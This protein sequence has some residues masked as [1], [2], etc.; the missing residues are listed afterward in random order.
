MPIPVECPS[1]KSTFR[2]KEEFV[3]KLGRCPSCKAQLTV[4]AASPNPLASGDRVSSHAQEGRHATAALKEP[5]AVPRKPVGEEDDDNGGYALA[6]GAANKAKV[7]R[8]RDGGVPGVGASAE[9]VRQ[10]AAPTE[11]TRTS[12]EI[13]TAFRG[14]IA[15]VRPSPMYALWL[16][17]V[18]GFM[19]LLPLI[20]VAIIGLVIFALGYHAVYDVAMLQQAGRG[21]ALK[22]ALMV[23]IV[24]L[25]CGA[26]VVAFLLK[27]LFAKPAKRPKRRAV[28]PKAEPLLYAF[29]DGVCTSVGA[30]RP[31][32]I[33]VDC[34]VNAAAGYA[35]GAFSIFGRKPVLVIGLGLVA[36]LDLKQL[37]GVMAHE[38]GHISQGSGARL[39][40]VISS[41][42][43]WFARVVYER[44]EW[45]ETLRGWSTGD[46][47]AEIVI[48][49]LARLAV[50]LARRV[51]W[52]L[53]HAG[54]LVN[55]VFLR[56]REY[57]ADRYEA[58]MVGA[59]VFVKTLRRIN[60]L[61]LA[62]Q[63]AMSDIQS[64]WQQR[65]LPDNYP[66]LILANVPQIP[67]EALAAYRKA[68]DQVRTGLFDTHPSDRDRIARAKG[69]GQGDGIFH[70]DGPASD[71][72]RDFD[73]LAR[74]VTFDYY[75][76]ILG[77]DI[78]REQLY[79][80]A[81]L[82]E[83][84]A[85]AQEGHVAAERFF[86][87]ALPMSR[88]LALPP[89]YPA[90]PSDPKGAKHAL[91]KARTGQQA[92][93]EEC[94]AANE[95]DSAIHVRL[96]QT[97]AAVI[98]LKSGNTLAADDWGLRA[99]TL[100]AAESA[101]DEA[102]AEL[103]DLAVQFE[104][105]ATAATRRLT[106]AL[107]MLQLDAVAD[108]AAEGRERREEART[109]YPCAA[110]LAANVV[111]PLVRV[112]RA[113]QVLGLL[114]ARCTEGNNATNQ[115]LINAVLRGA[116]DLSERLRELRS[117]LGDAIDYPFEHAREDI[118]LG[119]FALPAILPAETDVVG[120]LETANTAIDRLMGLYRRT[121]GRLTVTAEEVERVLGLGPIAID[122]SE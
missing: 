98:L 70:L 53:L 90:A 57:D 89:N 13:L 17:I 29:I 65:R 84:Q 20:Y 38:L 12:T 32:R 3:G 31:E 45:D 69:E 77:R 10:A 19:V 99:P 111:S 40:D 5:A 80:V 27:P 25:I 107:A 121:L 18:A 97:D 83:T 108:R 44:D 7:V 86:L 67:K 24:P 11:K 82:V 115:P 47:G 23:Y 16:L 52:V 71:V 105:F 50:W 63:L 35:G 59:K 61:Q 72:F 78:S 36:G 62:G 116:G 28:D 110:H 92:A 9:G 1:C 76:S 48:G 114:V 122:E 22:I 33:E 109:L 43:S 4:G 49:A 79:S 119:R 46:H 73:A 112:L 113:Q 91:V 21:W 96:V 94:L 60:E 37:A 55:M 93:R 85:V 8:V 101:R 66:K 26:V 120:L 64:S 14:Q 95:R 2:V 117:K 30:P 58:R 39:M 42:N 88:P 118:T 103:R 100:R 74:S 34:S 68:V 51:L 15:P 102:L 81:E 54:H 41:I 6:G 87:K 104:P 106:Q 75:K 56:Q